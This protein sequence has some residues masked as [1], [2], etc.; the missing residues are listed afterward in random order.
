MPLDL[1]VSLALTKYWALVWRV[2][3]SPFVETEIRH[4]SL[5]HQSLFEPN[6]LH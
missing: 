2:Y 3:D 6:K 1:Y 4:R 5:Q